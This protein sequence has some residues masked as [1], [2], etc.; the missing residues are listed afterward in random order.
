MNFQ[1]FQWIPIHPKHC[2]FF[3][4]D[5]SQK[6]KIIIFQG[7]FLSPVGGNFANLSF[8]TQPP[9]L[10]ASTCKPRKLGSEWQQS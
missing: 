7:R 3:G 9:G 8:P 6:P 1:Y 10:T 2:S 5:D 4:V